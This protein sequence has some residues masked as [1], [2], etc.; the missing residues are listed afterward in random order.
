MALKIN[1]E[2]VEQQKRS[3]R[4]RTSRQKG[5]QYERVVA[6]KFEEKYGIKF[7]R[8]PQSGG[9][10]KNTSNAE[11]FRG[12]IIPVDRNV[13]LKV[14]IECKNQKACSTYKWID[15]A[16]QDCPEEKIPLVVFKRFNSSKSYVTMSL[17]DFFKLVPSVVEEV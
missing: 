16:E 6:K 2:K 4:G 17:E 14:H 9:F 3:R 10:A 13:K 7:A 12:D 5:A 8:T 15:Q 11:G 1:P